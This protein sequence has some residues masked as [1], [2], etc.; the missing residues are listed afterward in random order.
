MK[1]SAAASAHRELELGHEVLVAVHQ[2]VAR[3]AEVGFGAE[4]QVQDAK[5]TGDGQ[6][7]RGDPVVQGGD[8]AGA[9]PNM[10]LAR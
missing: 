7:G 2:V 1:A 8:R 5:R 3:E 10:S 9:G 4:L 6:S